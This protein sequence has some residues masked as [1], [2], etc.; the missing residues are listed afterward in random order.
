MVAVGTERSQGATFLDGYPR[1]SFEDEDEGNDE[2][3]SSW[4]RKQGFSRRAERPEPRANLSLEQMRSMLAP[5]DAISKQPKTP[6]EYFEKDPA[7]LEQLSAGVRVIHPTFGKGVVEAIQGS[8]TSG[9]VAI[10]FDSFEEQKRLVY[11]FAKLV[12]E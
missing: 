7:A 10:K 6:K 11:R 5:A 2:G 12:L 3:L 8:G 1:F 4:K 9:T